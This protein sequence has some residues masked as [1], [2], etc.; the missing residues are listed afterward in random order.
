MIT[1]TVLSLCGTVLIATGTPRQAA[2]VL[3]KCPREPTR[4]VLRL[5]GFALLA[6]SCAAT[7]ASADPYRQLVGWIGMASFEFFAISLVATVLAARR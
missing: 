7:F 1:A 2:L 3:K 6:S 5:A 4:R